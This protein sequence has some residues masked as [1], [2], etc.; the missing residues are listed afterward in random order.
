[1][2]RITHFKTQPINIQYW[3]YYILCHLNA[4]ATIALQ[5]MEYWDGT[6]EAGI[7]HAEDINDMQALSGETP[8][9]D[10]GTWIY[11]SQDELH[12]ELMGITGEKKLQKMIDF[13]IQDLKYLETRN[14]PY[15]GWDRKKQYEFKAELIQEHINYLGYIVSYFKLPLRRLRP[16]FCAIETLTREGIH[17]DQLNVELVITKIADFREDPKL[18]H[19]LK[20][21]LEKL[22]T[23][24]VTQHLRSFRNFAEWKAQNCGMQSAEMRNASRK[25]AESIPQKRGSNSIEDKT[26]KTTKEDKE[27][28]NDALT[29]NSSPQSSLSHSFAPSLSSSETK[30]EVVFTPEEEAVFALAGQSNIVYLKRD[31][32]HKESCALLVKKGVVTQEKMESL[33]THCNNTFLQGKMLNLKNL[34]NEVTG[35]LQLQRR[36]TA[37]PSESPVVSTMGKSTASTIEEY[38]AVQ[39][40]ILESDEARGGRGPSPSERA[41]LLARQKFL[42][43]KAKHEAALARG[44]NPL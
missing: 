22:G 31:N 12:W 13:L 9:Q 20:N 42:E 34:A 29:T 16:I 37:A 36:A 3:D 24:S 38:K 21:E 2:S 30:S 35:W 17:I 5:R 10:V 19:F 4:E 39:Q 14:N 28:K 7:S 41:K 27:R 32:G 6:K 1:M 26:K 43:G 18:P 15:K 25:N 44:E 23:L 8:T 33:I 40:R 11:K